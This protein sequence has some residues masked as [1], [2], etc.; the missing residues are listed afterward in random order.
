MGITL[1]P[2]CGLD[3]QHYT[4]H[5]DYM[6]CEEGTDCEWCGY[7]SEFMYGNHRVVVGRRTFIWGYRTPNEQLRRIS[8]LID[9]AI[10]IRL[11]ELG[12]AE[13]E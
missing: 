11:R 2:V 3:A 5:I 10:Q 12:I 8:R 6:L 7:S 9:K 4:D 13:A 1:C